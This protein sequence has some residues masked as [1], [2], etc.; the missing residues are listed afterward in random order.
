MQGRLALVKRGIG[1]KFLRPRMNDW[2][3]IRAG[4]PC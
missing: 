4:A 1:P 3:M 2:L